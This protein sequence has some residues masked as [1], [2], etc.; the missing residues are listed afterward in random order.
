MISYVNL[1]V[2]T[3]TFNLLLPQVLILHDK[4]AHSLVV[5]VALEEDIEVP[6]V[7]DQL[8]EELTILELLPGNG[9]HPLVAFPLDT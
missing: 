2:L 8:V 7:E 9:D 3:A 4:L 5:G 1:D 6:R